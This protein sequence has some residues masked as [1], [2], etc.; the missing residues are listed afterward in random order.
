MENFDLD[1]SWN[2]TRT[3]KSESNPQKNPGVISER[4]SK[5]VNPVNPG[6][7]PE[8]NEEILKLISERIPERML[9]EIPQGIL[10]EINE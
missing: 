9:G 6:E 5:G 2:Q 10:G 8:I 3:R 4:I 1:W 7:A